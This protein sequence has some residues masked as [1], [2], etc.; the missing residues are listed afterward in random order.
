M[1]FR[2]GDVVF[3]F[4]AGASAPFGIPTMKQF[5]VDFERLLEKNGTDEE[6]K[7]YSNIKTTLANRLRREI[8]LEDIFTVIDG[9]INFDYE[10]LGLLSVYTFRE[11]LSKMTYFPSETYEADVQ[12]CRT[13]KNKFQK[14]V[15]DRCLIPNEAFSRITEVYHDFFNRF[16]LESTAAGQSV[17]GS[18]WWYSNWTMFT[19]NYDTCLEH[20]WRQ[21]ARVSLNTGFSVDEARRTWILNPSKFNEENLR[22]LKLHGSISWQIEP[23]EPVTEEQTMLGRSLV[24]REFIGEMMVYPVQE[25]EL[26]LEPYISMFVQLNR[27]LKRKS[28]WIIIGYSFNDLIIREIFLRNSNKKKKIVL[29]HPDAYKVRESRLNDLKGDVGLITEKFGLEH[30]FRNINYSIIG[31]LKSRPKY[32]TSETPIS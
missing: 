12:L 25:K 1:S 3:F 22:L 15:R 6:K 18:F 17:R 21:T 2:G 13:L 30:D 31:K 20:Y 10:R 28:T 8:D 26:Y 5:V 27:E 24:G 4:G 32:L 29:V 7:L 23:D 19:T 16:S 14:F 11:P 9:Y